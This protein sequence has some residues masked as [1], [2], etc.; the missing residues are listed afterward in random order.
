MRGKPQ[1]LVPVA[2]A[3]RLQCGDVIA[4][5]SGDYRI[6]SLVRGGSKA[7]VEE[8]TPGALRSFTLPAEYALAH[9]RRAPRK[10]PQTAM[11]LTVLRR[12]EEP[13]TKLLVLAAAE[14][15]L[16]AVD[17]HGLCALHHAAQQG[18]CAAVGSLLRHGCADR[19]D[20]IKGETALIKAARNRHVACVAALMAAGSDVNACSCTGHTALMMACTAGHLECARLLVEQG[21]AS[22]H[23][24]ECLTCERLDAFRIACSEGHVACAQLL[25]AHAEDAAAALSPSK[26]VKACRVAPLPCGG[27]AMRQWLREARSWTTPLHHLHQMGTRRATELLRSGADVHATT[28][29][30]EEAMSPL[31][32]ALALLAAHGA[33]APSA[34]KLVV[35]A[36][37]PWTPENAHLF[38]AAQRRQAAELGR[39]GKQLAR[40]YGSE[41]AY[42][43]WELWLWFIVPSCVHRPS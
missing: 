2:T 24:R 1:P 16:D 33:D 3:P 21:G 17:R 29:D 14:G 35:E 43:V 25:A 12:G 28:D 20:P 27:S 41:H 22:T 34:A 18:L 32:V 37:R 11:L 26:L 19:A 36:A 42:T 8:A 39:V 6:R 23:F 10:L 40:R 13:T 9:R 30:V 15:H 5:R 38:P 7:V 31:Q 4:L